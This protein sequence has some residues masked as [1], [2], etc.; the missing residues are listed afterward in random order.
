MRQRQKYMTLVTIREDFE[1]SDFQRIKFLMDK[2]KY[3]AKQAREHTSENRDLLLF[4]NDSEMYDWTQNGFKCTYCEF[5][6]DQFDIR[7]SGAS[8]MIT[9]ENLI[10]W[11]F[12][13][14]CDYGELSDDEKKAANTINMLMSCAS[15]KLKFYIG[16][17]YNNYLSEFEN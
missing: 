8:Y 6:E 11:S 5:Q 4:L 7:T 15:P 3:S 14:H 12:E 10:Q 9:E 1:S 17:K 16:N 13:H 2:M